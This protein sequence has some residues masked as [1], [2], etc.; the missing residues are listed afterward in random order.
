M[1]RSH[2]K[3]GTD[4]DGI[5]QQL[6]NF[7]PR[8]HEGNDASMQMWCADTTISIHVPTKGTTAILHNCISIFHAIST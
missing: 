8:P 2:E 5:W 6:C 7:N 1:R 4:Q 3:N